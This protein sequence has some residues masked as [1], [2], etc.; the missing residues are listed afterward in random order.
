M[1][2]PPGSLQQRPPDPVIPRFEGTTHGPLGDGGRGV[3]AKGQ[4]R[5]PPSPIYF[6]QV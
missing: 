4:E 1:T 3:L 2:S 5:P 6:P